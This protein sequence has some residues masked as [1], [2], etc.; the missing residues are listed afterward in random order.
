MPVPA[1]LRRRHRA[2]GL[3]DGKPVAEAALVR[4]S[5]RAGL[6]GWP[7]GCE[8]RLSTGAYLLMRPQRDIRNS[9]AAPA[10]A[11]IRATTSLPRSLRAASQPL[12]AFPE[13]WADHVHTV[14]SAQLFPL[15]YQRGAVGMYR[16]M[17]QRQRRAAAAEVQA[18]AHRRR[19]HRGQPV[20]AIQRTGA[21]DST[22]ESS[23]RGATFVL[24]YT[25]DYLGYLPRTEDF[26]QIADVPL[27]ES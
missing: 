27:E 1:G 2:V 16:N 21:G 26:R 6:T 18:I 22:T 17:R 20:R 12:P 9:A 3:L 7:G 25:N 10:S 19:C 5:R 4:Q 13:L 23:S 8:G 24:G 11:S 14:N 15:P